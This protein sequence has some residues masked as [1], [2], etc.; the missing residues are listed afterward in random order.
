MAYNRTTAKTKA[1]ARKQD[2]A[3]KPRPAAVKWPGKHPG[4]SGRRK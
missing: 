2:L 3:R 1:V 4:P